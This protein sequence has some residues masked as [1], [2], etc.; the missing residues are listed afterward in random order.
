MINYH[1]ELVKALQT[2]L[3]TYYEMTVSS[4]TATP[5]I[6]YIERDNSAQETGDTLGYSRISYTV[7]VWGNDLGQLQQYALMI[8]AVMRPLGFKRISSG[9]LYD[10]QSTMIQKILAYEALAQEEF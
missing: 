9:E 2:I 10:N 3:P 4:K 6:T 1:T 7:K 5:C 8:D